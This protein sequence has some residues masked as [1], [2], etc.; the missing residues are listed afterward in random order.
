VR[1]LLA[2][3]AQLLELIQYLLG[4]IAV[5]LGG[6]FLHSYNKYDIF[7]LDKTLVHD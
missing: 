4:F 7:K 5:L 1:E 2:A 6:C 3:V